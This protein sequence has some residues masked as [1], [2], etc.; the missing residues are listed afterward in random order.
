VAEYAEAR[1]QSLGRYASEPLLHARV[2]L[3]V[4]ADPALRRPV[5]A[6]G[7]LDLNGRAV[8][9]QVAAGTPQGAVDALHD[10]LRRRVSR[11]ARD[12]S[13]RRGSRASAPYRGRRAGELA[14][15]PERVYRPPAERQVVRRKTYAP[16]VSTV[17]E[18]ALELELM[19]YDFHLFAE[20]GCGQHSVLYRSG[21]GLRLV[22]AHPEPRRVKPGSVLVEINAQPAP[23]LTLAVAIRR[24]DPSGQ[25]FLFYVDPERWQGSVLYQRYDGHYGLITAT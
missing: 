12:A 15:R 4:Q 7:N 23:Q 13:I 2:R 6:Q 11:M 5:M 14:R 1:I 21:D 18:A 22:Q 8:R 20:A 16:P 3:T 24:L 17:D 25:P 10:V 19:D 9:A